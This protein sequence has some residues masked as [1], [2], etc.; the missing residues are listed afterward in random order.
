MQVRVSQK[1]G[2]MA[3][4]GG[5]RDHVHRHS[6]PHDRPAARMG[7][8]SSGGYSGSAVMALAQQLGLAPPA[9]AGPLTCLCV[10]C[11]VLSHLGSAV[12]CHSRMTMA[13]PAWL[14]RASL[15]E[16]QELHPTGFA[17]KAILRTTTPSWAA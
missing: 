4:S 13:W 17:S 9:L 15:P 10:V 1:N 12:E 3:P 14:L 5:A 7:M 16:K 6:F 2:H 8:H 11:A